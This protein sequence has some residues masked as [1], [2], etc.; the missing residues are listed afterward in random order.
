MVALATGGMSGASRDVVV[1]GLGTDHSA[2]LRITSGCTT[3]GLL[4]PFLLVMAAIVA[5]S[6]IPVIRV[7]VVTAAGALMLLAVNILRLTVIAWATSVWGLDHGF[8]ISHVLVG[9]ILALTG[10]AATLVISV[11]LL[12]RGGNAAR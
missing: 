11:R 1:F 12:V 10:F 7:L 4:V 6:T 9:S 3:A 5:K 2:G 8:E